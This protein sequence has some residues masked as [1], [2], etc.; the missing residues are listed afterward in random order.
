MVLLEQADV[1]KAY[2]KLSLQLH[3]D[4]N[5]ACAEEATRAFE[6]VVAAYEVLSSPDKR[7]AFD[8]YGELV[9]SILLLERR[10]HAVKSMA[11]GCCRRRPL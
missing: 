11:V 7:E 10:E 8:S 1:R 2:R 4:K 3:P 9:E 5:T 6:E